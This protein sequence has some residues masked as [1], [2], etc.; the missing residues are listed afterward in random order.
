MITEQP[1]ID[2]ISP[3]RKICYGIV[4]PGKPVSPGVPVLRVN[5]FTEGRLFTDDVMSVDQS[6][7]SKY[8]RSR[9]KGGE[10][11][12]TLVG[13][14][15]QSAIAGP[16]LAGWNV[17]R[18][19]GVIPIDDPILVKWVNF[20]IRSEAAQ[21]YFLQ[22]ANTTVQTTV[23]LGDLA[24]LPIPMPSRFEI[25][26]IV[27]ILSTL[28]DKIELNRRMNE[29]LEAQARALFRD[30]F[31]D[32]GPVKAKAKAKASDPD[33]PTPY[34]AP[35]LWSLFPDR[36]GED[37]VPE[38]WTT[39]RLDEIADHHTKTLKPML[40]PDR[41]F[42]HFS[43]PA[44]DKGEQPL[45][46]YGEAIKSNKTKIPHGA[47]LLSKLNPETPRV[48]WPEPARETL[49][50]A[51]TEFLAFTP[52]AGFSQTLLYCLFKASEF[53]QVLQGMVTGTSK[54][55][56]RISPPALKTLEALTGSDVAFRAFDTHVSPL[57]KKVIVNRAE[58]QTLALTRDFLLPKLMSGEIRVGEA[59]KNLNMAL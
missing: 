42:Q 37:G 28:D 4:Q 26:A 40:E 29:T 55:H 46:E 13:S 14:V 17:A 8:P 18:A 25:E 45:S 54:S 1:L 44:Y 12:V 50:I 11:L 57:F 56:Q 49:Q 19:V 22:R 9:L 53:R 31:V 20:V 6:I 21:Q 35:D 48:W 47:I 5:N 33:A 51:S 3:S 41:L 10:L 2:L 39:F 27:S 16:E 58:N 36:I 7:E 15:G 23:N 24:V 34:L 32:F 52:K 30:W 43:L 59:E 38:G